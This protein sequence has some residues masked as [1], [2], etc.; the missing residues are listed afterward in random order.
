M[1]LLPLNKPSRNGLLAMPPIQAL[2]GKGVL[3]SELWT[4]AILGQPIGRGNNSKLKEAAWEE[5]ANEINHTFGL[6]LA[7]VQVRK[8]FNDI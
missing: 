3:V 7:H 6:K 1:Q 2:G 8:K 4:K 5:V